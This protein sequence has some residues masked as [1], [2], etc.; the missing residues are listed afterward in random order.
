MNDERDELQ[1]DDDA[2]DELSISGKAP[3]LR[4]L[5]SLIILRKRILDDID[6]IVELE[7]VK[8]K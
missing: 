1:E 4:R 2:L 6:S 7:A 8:E 5:Q 3:F